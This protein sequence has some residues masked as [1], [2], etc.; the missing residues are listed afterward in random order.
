MQI[1]DIWGDNLP[2]KKETLRQNNLGRPQIS[3]NKRGI[4]F[5][6]KTVHISIHKL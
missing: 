5:L 6:V 4:Y 1:F 2:L 3:A